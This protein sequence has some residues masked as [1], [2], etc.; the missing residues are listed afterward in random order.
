MKNNLIRLNKYI[1]NSGLCTR[2]EADNYILNGRVSVDGKTIT[3]L[4]SKILT[5]S[6]VR[7]DGKLIVNKQFKY[8]LL[9]K[10]SDF[11]LNKNNNKNIFNLVK[12]SK[13]EEL[14]TDEVI[15]NDFLGLVVLSND[16]SFNHE[17]LKS[18]NQKKQLFHIK[19]D[20]ELCSENKEQIRKTNSK[21]IKI[22]SIDYVSSSSKNEIGI[23][24]TTD[25]V[26]NIYN[27]FKK[28]DYKI[29]SLDRV[30]LANF[31]KKDLGRGKWRF[32]EKIELS[33]FSSF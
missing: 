28:L 20:N 21:K 7:V 14:D 18:L 23:E 12:S 29:V 32:I 6:K 30:L 25:S 5:N 26:S 33:N 27:I 11:D 2:R 22:Y 4:G 9:N 17:F 31:S 3:I 24:L 1:S 16:K 13:V 15:N 10:P 8:L 19:L